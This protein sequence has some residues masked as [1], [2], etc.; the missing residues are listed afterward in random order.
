MGKY[1]MLLTSLDLRDLM[2]LELPT[3]SEQRRLLFRP[4][5][6]FANHVYELVNYYVFDNELTKPKIE[7]KSH[8]RKYWGICYGAT[9][10]DYTGSYCRINLMDKWFC[11]QWFITTLAH[12]MVHQY[13]W[14]IL[15]PERE[16]DGKDWL[17]SHGPSFYQFKPHLHVHDISL[18]TAHSQRRWFKH[19][20]LFKA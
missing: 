14:D 11:P 6:R 13:Q 3:I 2:N 5:L 1:V 8:C 20:N 18:K 4:N 7:L 12:E 19:Q 15:G 10:K 16:K 9:D 17:M